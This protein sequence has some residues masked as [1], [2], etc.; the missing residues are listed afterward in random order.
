M[1]TKRR[2]PTRPAAAKATAGCCIPALNFGMGTLNLNIASSTTINPAA[3]TCSLCLEPIIFNSE[4]IPP[5]DEKKRKLADTGTNSLPTFLQ[6]DDPSA[7]DATQRSDERIERLVGASPHLGRK[8][9]LDSC[10]AGLQGHWY[11]SGC[12]FAQLSRGSR[13][14]GL[15]QQ[16]WSDDV[17]DRACEDAI[18]EKQG[19]TKLARKQK[20]ITEDEALAQMDS[21]RRVAEN[22][23]QVDR[24]VDWPPE[25]SDVLLRIQEVQRNLS[26]SD[27]ATDTVYGPLPVDWDPDAQLEF[28]ELPWYKKDEMASFVGTYWEG[29][30]EMTFARLV[31]QVGQGEL[32]EW[33]VLEREYWTYANFSPQEAAATRQMWIK[34]WRAYIQMKHDKTWGVYMIDEIAVAFFANLQMY[35]WDKFY[36]A[37]VGRRLRTA[38]RR[39]QEEAAWG[40]FIRLNARFH[41]MLNGREADQFLESVSETGTSIRTEELVELSRE[42]KRLGS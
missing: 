33:P 24:G 4:L 8:I 19:E 30:R 39:A 41:A 1:D 38:Q 12:V 9:L 35:E 7:P 5:M 21:V 2:M 6:R 15:S 14:C 23:R 32:S 22:A 11:H 37:L 25:K 31:W 20:R 3:A 17:V 42:L 16:R 10:T 26:S 18:R 13:R 27:F 29:M 40:A 36:R 34:K 28:E